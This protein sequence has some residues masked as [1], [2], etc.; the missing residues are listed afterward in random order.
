M[1][2]FPCF[3]ASCCNS[4]KSSRDSKPTIHYVVPSSPRDQFSYPR[5][6]SSYPTLIGKESRT[7]SVKRLSKFDLSHHLRHLTLYSLQ[8]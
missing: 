6:A 2:E 7:C 3:C 1:A 4:L 8:M 5:P